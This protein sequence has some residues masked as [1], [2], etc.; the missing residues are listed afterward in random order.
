MKTMRF[1]P[2]LLT[3]LV[4]CI[5]AGQSFFWLPEEQSAALPAPVS[6]EMGAF[7]QA[8]SRSEEIEVYQLLPEAR[9]D[10]R[11]KGDLFHDYPI[12]KAVILKQLD[13]TK[14]MTVFWQ[15]DDPEGSF[16]F[17]FNPRHGLRA[18]WEGRT[19]D[20]C[21]CYECSAV[22][23]YIDDHQVADWIWSYKSLPLLNSALS[24]FSD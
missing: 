16:A 15:D 6:K 23:A 1:I 2:L 13:S 14:M 24:E 10:S 17:C 3:L 5:A 22:K 21:I 20:L 9:H 11:D 4:V 7:K 18:K 8:F 12:E 19:Y